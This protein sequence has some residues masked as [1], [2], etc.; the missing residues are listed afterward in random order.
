[1]SPYLPFIGRWLSASAKA[2][3]HP[4]IA[5]LSTAATHARRAFSILQQSHNHHVRLMGMVAHP[6]AFYILDDC[7]GAARAFPDGITVRRHWPDHRRLLFAGTTPLVADLLVSWTKPNKFRPALCIMFF[8][9]IALFDYRAMPES[10]ALW[11]QGRPSR[12]SGMP[13]S[14]SRRRTT[15]RPRQMPMRRRRQPSRQRLRAPCDGDER[16]HRIMIR[17][18]AI[19][20]ARR[21]VGS[22]RRTSLDC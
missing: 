12:R 4:I 13:K 9:A 5:V 11:V 15:I 19:L 10:E 22:S 21:R 20:P 7:L 3:H 2:D 1:M 18:A 6:V 14:W 16:D 17:P 8:A